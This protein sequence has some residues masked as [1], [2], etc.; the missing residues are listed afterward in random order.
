MTVA[1]SM[2]RVGLFTLLR[3]LLWGDQIKRAQVSDHGAFM[4]G[5]GR[6]WAVPM[7]LVFSAGALITLGQRQIT[8]LV[9]SGS[10][11]NH[12]I[13]SSARCWRLPW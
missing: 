9:S 7:T 8:T 10:I 4:R 1:V 13:W 5:L 3:R 11:T 12:W 6:A 2:P